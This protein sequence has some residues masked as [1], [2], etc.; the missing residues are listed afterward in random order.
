MVFAIASSHGNTFNLQDRWND[1]TLGLKIDDWVELVDD[2]TR[3]PG[4]PGTPLQVKSVPSK[5]QITVEQD[6]PEINSSAAGPKA[7]A[8]PP[9]LR[10]WDQKGLVNGADKIVENEWRPCENGIEF[11]FEHAPGAD[12]NFY[13]PG[14]YWYVP[15]R[16]ANDGEILVSAK[17]NRTE[18][19]IIT[20]R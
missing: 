7:S 3:G 10:R 17:D 6:I 20:R 4:H 5:S 15:V 8:R 18:L 11:R 1:P 9:Y 12:I 2:V 16:T 14:D 13:R 19:R